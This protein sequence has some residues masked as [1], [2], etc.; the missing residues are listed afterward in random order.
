MKLILMVRFFEVPS[1]GLWTD[2]YV[3]N[4]VD[5]R[6]PHLFFAVTCGC[7]FLI[8]LSLSPTNND[9]NNHT[10][11]ASRVLAVGNAV[12]SPPSSSPFAGLPEFLAKAFGVLPTLTKKKEEN[13]KEEMDNHLFMD[14]DEECYLGKDGT[15]DECVDFDPPH[16]ASP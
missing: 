4:N 3:P 13:T 10:A 11:P 5:V 7:F 14:L 2:R 15:L 6:R 12:R 16:S 1:F 9:N 8:F